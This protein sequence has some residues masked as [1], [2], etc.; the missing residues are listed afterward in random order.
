MFY[1]LKE[2]NRF[3]ISKQCLSNIHPLTS[4]INRILFNNAP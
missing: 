4:A 2:D 3:E 1:E